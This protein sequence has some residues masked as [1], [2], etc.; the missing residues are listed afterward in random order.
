[1]ALLRLRPALVLMAAAL[2][3]ALASSAAAAATEYQVKA[4]FLFNFSQFV[5]W[6]PAAFAGPSTPIT[7]CV[8]GRDRFGA[9]L[10]E[11]V[12]GE[13]VNDRPLAVQRYRRVE[14]LGNCH[15]LFID[16]SEASKLPQIL[17]PL[18]A[19]NILTVSDM[20]DF[21]GR[22]GMIHFITVGNKIRLRVNLAAAQAASLEI[23]SKLL[24]PAQIVSSQT[25]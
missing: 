15:I 5:D 20:D 18:A 4:V 22:G 1:M 3:L 19:R 2:S 12:Q 6:P 13:I 25:P 14:E 16:R 10:D 21:A 23:S 17:A 8:L 24:R 9:A 11:S 7:I